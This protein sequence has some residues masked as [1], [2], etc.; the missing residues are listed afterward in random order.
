VCKVIHTDLKPENVSLCLTD[1]EVH[2]ISTKGF[3]KPI[4]LH[5]AHQAHNQE[6]LNKALV[7]EKAS[8]SIRGRGNRE[9]DTEEKLDK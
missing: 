7:K 6:L 1:Q 5:D 3:L 4:K 9:G 2:E 8:K